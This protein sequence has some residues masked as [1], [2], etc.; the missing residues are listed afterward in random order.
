MKGFFNWFVK[1][2]AYPIQKLVFR[3]KIYYEDKKIQSRKI[4]GAAMVVSNH[5]SVYDYAVELFVFF[6]KTVN[7]QMA[8]VL[9]EKK[10][11][12]SFLKALGGIKVDRNA[13]DF[14]FIEK[15]KEIL[16]NG[17]AVGVFP[18]S[19]IPKEGEERPLE[20]KPSAAYLALYASVPIIPVYTNGEYFG[21]KR[22]RVI[23]G[24]PFMTSDYYDEEKTEK[25]NMENISASLKRRIIEL[26]RLLDEK[27]KGKRKEKA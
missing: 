26:G 24:K 20:F 8:E 7:Y 11:L 19:R 9:F 13:F 21:K 23:I 3:T 10:P 4:K 22:A 18:E 15:S 6:S 2:T 1:I 14:G 12:G 25:E 5:T 17:G 27:R 16:D